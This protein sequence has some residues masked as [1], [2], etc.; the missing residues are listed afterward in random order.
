MEKTIL[1]TASI[2]GLTAVI[3]GAFGAHALKA[4]LTPDQLASFQ[5]GVR[6]QFIHTLALI[7]V[8]VLLL[9]SSNKML[10]NAAWAF[11]IGMLLFSGSIYLLTAGKMMGWSVSWLGPITP[12][13]GVS[14]IVGWVMFF[15]GVGKMEK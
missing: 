10:R 5:T 8:G 4:Q 1:K 15:F 13:G 7:A 6:Y 12:L 3:L 9:I 14:L 11:T 2:F